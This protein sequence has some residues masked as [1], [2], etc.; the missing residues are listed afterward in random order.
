MNYIVC[1][2]VCQQRSKK[3]MLCFTMLYFTMLCFALLCGIIPGSTGVIP[4]KKGVIPG[5]TSKGLKK[6]RQMLLKDMHI[7]NSLLK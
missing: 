4:G 5:I 7:Q 1:H 3:A 2:L 6:Q